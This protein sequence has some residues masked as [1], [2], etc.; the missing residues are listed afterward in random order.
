MFGEDRHGV[1]L[2]WFWQQSDINLCNI[3]GTLCDTLCENF[4][5]TLRPRLCSGSAKG[6][7]WKRGLFR[8][9]YFL[10]I[11]EFRDSRAP[12]DC[13]PF[14]EILENPDPRILAFFDFLAFFAFRFS[15]FFCALSFFFQG[16]QGFREK[17]C[18]FRGFLCFFGGSGNLAEFRDFRDSRDS[19]SEKTLFVMTPLS[20]PD[21]CSKFLGSEPN[22]RQKCDNTIS[23]TSLR[24]FV[25][26]T[27]SRKISDSR[28]SPDSCESCESIHTNHATKILRFRS[29]GT[30]Q[31]S[32]KRSRSGKAILEALR[33]FRA[34]LGAALSAPFLNGLFSRKYSRGKT[35]QKNN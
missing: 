23:A 19:S 1:S 2:K 4:A 31:L 3:C 16:F 35:A 18:F 9:V 14:L 27:P 12:P 6:V 28:E 20:G 17:I 25:P 21:M 26:R 30:S 13:F 5:T 22:L 8:E 34:I 10:E 11:L 7:F 15:W 29:L 24:Y 32:G 33:K